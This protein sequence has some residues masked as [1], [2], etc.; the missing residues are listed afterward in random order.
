MSCS[1]LLSPFVDASFR[2]QRER[3]RKEESYHSVDYSSS[4]RERQEA[5]TG[6]ASRRTDDVER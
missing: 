5:T 4:Y 2:L 6:E 1:D 3:E